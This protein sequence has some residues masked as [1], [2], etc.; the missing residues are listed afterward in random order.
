MLHSIKNIPIIDGYPV[1]EVITT[2]NPDTILDFTDSPVIV[3]H[4]ANVIAFK[5]QDGPVQEKGVNGC[6]VDTLIETARHMLAYLNTK[7]P[8]RENEAAINA[9]DAAMDALIQRRK[10]RESRCVE[11]SNRE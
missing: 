4:E 6:Q 5:I 8:C 2:D 11:G 3:H 7:M 1:K 10:D 9:L